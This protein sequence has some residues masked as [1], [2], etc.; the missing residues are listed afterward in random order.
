MKTKIVIL[1]LSSVLLSSVFAQDNEE[2]PV[3]DTSVK[4]SGQWFM[5]YRGNVPS[6]GDDAFGLNA[7][8]FNL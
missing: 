6:E 8:I 1:L 5:A 3:L 4:I 2:T 7:R